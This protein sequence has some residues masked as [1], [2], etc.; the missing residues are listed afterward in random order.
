V[1]R[2]Y[3]RQKLAS[4]KSECNVITNRYPEAASLVEVYKELND[5]KIL[6]GSTPAKVGEGCEWTSIVN[7]AE[8]NRANVCKALYRKPRFSALC[9]MHVVTLNELKAAPSSEKPIKSVIR[10]FPQDSP[11]EDITNEVRI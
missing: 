8:E 11:A 7:S 3:W 1:F 9:E 5:I 2:K 6:A 10:H 4:L